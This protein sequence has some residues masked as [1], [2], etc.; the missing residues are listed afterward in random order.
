MAMFKRHMWDAIFACIVATPSL[1]WAQAGTD[2]GIQ[3]S[4]N[5]GVQG[6]P[7]GGLHGRPNAGT[8][9]RTS[10][11]GSSGSLLTRRMAPYTGP[12]VAGPSNAEVAAFN[13][14]RAAVL[15]YA[16]H[17]QWPDP[18]SNEMFN[19]L[20]DAWVGR[21]RRTP[22][23]VNQA[24]VTTSSGHFSAAATINL[25][26][27]SSISRPS[28]V[29]TRGLTINDAIFWNEFAD[30]RYGCHPCNEGLTHAVDGFLAE[31]VTFDQMY[32]ALDQSAF[33][34]AMAAANPV[35]VA[36]LSTLQRADAAVMMG[37]AASAVELYQQHLK[38]EAEDSG[39]KIRLAFAMLETGRAADATAL[40][41]MTYSDDPAL[42]DVSLESV[43]PAWGSGRA[44]RLVTSAVSHANRTGA[45]SAWM[46]VALLME[47]E[48]RRELAGRMLDR[49]RVAGLDTDL[50]DRLDAMI[51]APMP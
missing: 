27:G 45:A 22:I 15:G 12:V 43:I 3:G 5:P 2:A 39:A 8:S 14:R 23:S 18:A 6:T 36:P 7:G 21:Y 51:E 33:S 17:R 9:V 1:A 50:C 44:R 47:A 48:G 10:T 42:A 40:L 28:L 34:A 41:H 20:S 30:Y 19:E 29:S 38:A 24:T 26:I 4:P 31:P 11:G 16:T 37:D 49:A 25:G 32:P 46:T 35:Q 13:S